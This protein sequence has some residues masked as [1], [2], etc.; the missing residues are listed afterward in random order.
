MI[1]I[2]QAE[3]GDLWIPRECKEAIAFLDKEHVR[4]G[5]KLV[6]S[7][8][9]GERTVEA[10][11][12]YCEALSDE[13]YIVGKGASLDKLR[14]E[15]FQAGRDIIC[16]NEAVH[17][18]EALR[19]PNRITCIRQDNAG[20][21]ILPLRATVLAHVKI[22]E[23]YSEYPKVVLFDPV[24]DLGFP[25]LQVTAAAA[26]AVARIAKCT[27]VSLYGFDATTT[28]DLSYTKYRNKWNQS[29]D[30]KQLLNQKDILSTVTQGMNVTWYNPDLEKCQMGLSRP[31]NAGHRQQHPKGTIKTSTTPMSI[32]VSP[33]TAQ[34]EL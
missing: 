15:H 12:D 27:Q 2:R 33:S 1:H 23:L 29:S 6:W 32:T 19:L 8:P 25:R 9:V 30:N 4:Q 26:L 11:A 31:S 20:L 16:I 28:G 14:K 21:E 3:N 10:F 13:I 17:A 24:E 5:N 34:S 22:A 18:I 7:L